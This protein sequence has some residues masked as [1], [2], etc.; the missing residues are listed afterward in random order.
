MRNKI[1]RDLNRLWWAIKSRCYDP[2]AD[3]YRWYGAQGVRVCERWLKSFDAFFR[4]M[5]PSYVSGKWIDRLDNS[6]GYDPDNCRWVTPRESNLNKRRREKCNRGH[7]LDGLSK[8]NRQY[9][10]TCHAITQR[11]RRAHGG[12]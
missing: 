4:D 1:R 12:L 11:A 8:G 10:K 6:R 9:C 2:K 3:S 5:A 7:T